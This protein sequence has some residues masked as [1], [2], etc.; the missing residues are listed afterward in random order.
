[1]VTV[2]DRKDLMLMKRLLTL[3]SAGAMAG[4]MWAGGMAGAS[5]ASASV[6]GMHPQP[7]GPI[8]R[9]HVSGQATGLP[10]ISTNWSGYAAVASQQF[11]SVH[12][13]FTQPKIKCTGIK[14]QW[15]S[16]WVGLDGFLSNTVEQDGTFAM[17]GG[18]NN[19]TPRYE[20]WFEMF[21]AGSV[22]VFKVK[23]GDK[24]DASVK[25]SGGK[26]T[27][28]IADL[29][30]HKKHTKTA[31]CASCQRSSAEWIVERPALCNNSGKN[32]FITRLANFHVTKMTADTASVAGGGVQGI[33]NFPNIPIFM[34]DPLKS[35]GFISLAT[36]GPL[37]NKAFSVTWDRTGNTVPIT[38]GPKM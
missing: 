17:C 13:T 2:S 7:G 19:K 3:V 4:L 27:L 15:T 9:A 18:K 20:A 36:V 37:K 34:V 22:N 32:C 33:G 14:N 24:I 26:F 30:S 1:M 12:T 25:F 10:T 21:P 16:A 5:G 38:L 11:T 29:T 35:G 6:S 23:P 8:A 28:T 31:S